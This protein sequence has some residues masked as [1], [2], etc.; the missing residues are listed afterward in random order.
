MRIG[1]DATA[2]PAQPFGAG[3]YIIQLIRALAGLGGKDDLVVFVHRSRRAIIGDVAGIEWVNVPDKP[4]WRR[5][6]WEQLALPRLARRARLD[7]LHSPHYTRPFWLPCKSIVT[8]HDMTF[9]LYPELH[10]QAKRLFFPAA[11]RA[12]APLADAL[13]AVS[14]NT[15]QDAIRLLH[16]PPQKVFTVHH[17]VTDDFK[18]INEPGLLEN[19]RHKYGL[20]SQ[21]ILY[22]G[23]VEPR[24]NLPL[25]LRSFKKAT[26]EGIQASLVVAGSFG[27]MVDAVFEQIRALGLETKVLFTGYIPRQD[28]PMIYNLADLLVYPTLYEGFGLPVLEAMACGLPVVATEVSSI[29]EVIGEAGVLVPPTDEDALAQAILSVWRDSDLRRRLSEQG[30]ERALTFTWQR[31]AQ[32]T[33]WIYHQ[34]LQTRSTN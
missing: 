15:R 12:S 31:T 26:D 30:R 19:V 17:G 3:V 6:L 8:L 14:E 9:F 1:I 18:P 5:L 16:L 7:L 4:P 13:I 11:I 2:L 20:P 10:T 32:E 21:F 22:V 23:L 29:P 34:V 33:A 27:W 25:L 24:K 28:L